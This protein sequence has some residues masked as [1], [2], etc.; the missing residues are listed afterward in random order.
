MYRQGR[1]VLK[2]NGKAVKG[3]DQR[4]IRAIGKKSAF[5]EQVSH[6]SW[7]MY[8]YTTLETLY[9]AG[10]AVPKP[11]ASSENAI[12]MSYHG[13]AFMPAPT[14]SE[15]ELAPEEVEPLFEE[16]MRNIALMLG[17]NIVHGDLSAYNIL[18]W[19]G[20]I[21]IIDFPQVIDTATNENAF[22]IFQRDI[23]RVCD[24]FIRLGMD[25]DPDAIIGEYWD[26]YVPLDAETIMADFSRNAHEEEKD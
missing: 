18:Y 12:L 9:Q 2:S 4:M 24:Y 1:E 5:G 7:L 17:F 8:E 3:S 13:D 22:E 25:L 11:I 10:G 20:N 15:V 19:E 21:T 6:T 23:Q 26:H 16:I 14:L